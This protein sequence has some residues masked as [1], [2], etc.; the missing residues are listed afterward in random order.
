MLRGRVLAGQRGRAIIDA[1]PCFERAVLLDPELV[2][3]WSLLAD[4]YRLINIYGM[5]PAD[6]TI[7]HA[8]R[9]LDRALAL[10]PEH[11]QALSTLAN[12]AATYD[13]D[14]ERSVALSSRALV[15]D[16]SHVQ[17]MVERAFILAARTS[18]SAERIDESLRAL[19]KARELD[20]L[21]GWA[22]A[23]QAFSLTCVNHLD[24]ALAA[25]RASVELDHNAFTGRWALV[26]VLSERGQTAEA[27]TAATDALAMSGRHPRILAELASIH[28]RCGELDAVRGI[29]AELEDRASKSYVEH[30]VL[31]CVH[32][33]L[34]EIEE[35]RRHV[36]LGIEQHEIWWHFAKSPAWAPF[37]ADA[38]GAAMLAKYGFA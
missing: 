5:A 33:C 2:E 21:N 34:G 35:A 32:A 12:I 23:M 31:G 10:D 38:E 13:N 37:R 4:S 20:P 28:A 7:V 27:I 15:R 22:A 26:W 25:A 6:A 17:A 8:R 36:A 29:L 11:A 18:T 14:V 24:E 30:S 16:P 19:E 1:I 9:A 3:A